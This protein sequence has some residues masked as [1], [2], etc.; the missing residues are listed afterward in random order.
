MSDPL[1]RRRYR[2]AGDSMYPRFR[3]GDEIEVAL[4]AYDGDSSGP[5]P[6]EIVLARHPLKRGVEMVKRVL[7]VED[8]GRVFVVGDAPLESRD[9][10]GFG[11]LAPDL[12]LGRVVD[13]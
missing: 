5:Q 12:I 3:D 8:D 4:D 2:V 10:R 13:Q 11:P 7:R 1:R 9:S 6:G